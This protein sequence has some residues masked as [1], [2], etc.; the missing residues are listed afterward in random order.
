MPPSGKCPCR[1]AP[2]AA[3]VDN[4]EK[5]KNIYKTQLLP[6]FLTVDQRKQALNS[7]D[8]PGTLY[9]HPWQDKPQL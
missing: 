9:S 6:S 2:A 8:P 3:M 7:Q 1:I 5:K 4:L